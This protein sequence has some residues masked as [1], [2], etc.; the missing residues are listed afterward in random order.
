[1][2]APQKAAQTQLGGL[3]SENFDGF[4]KDEILGPH[5][6]KAAYFQNTYP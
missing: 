5:P 2:K 6:K 1:M 4:S 3:F